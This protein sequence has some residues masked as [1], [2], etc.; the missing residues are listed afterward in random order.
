MSVR[1]IAVGLSI[2]L[3]VVSCNNSKTRCKS[4]E[5]ASDSIPILSEQHIKD[6][7]YKDPQ[8]ALRLIDSAELCR[9]LPSF[10][11]D[12]LR[13]MI[14]S[15]LRMPRVSARYGERAYASD[16]VRNSDERMLWLCDLQMNNYA[17]MNDRRRSS[18]YALK[19]LQLSRRINN[20]NSEAGFLFG[21]GMN[22]RND[23]LSRRADSCFSAAV[24]LLETSDNVR[25]M[26]SLSFFYGNMMGY[27]S[28]EDRYGEMISLG[29]KREALIKRMSTMQ[30]PPEGYIDQQ[31]AYLYSKMAVAYL[32]LG[33]RVKAEQCFKEFT[34]TKYGSATPGDSEAIPYLICSGRYAQAD[35]LCT[36]YEKLIG[37]DT[38]VRD[39]MALLDNR[40][41]LY[42]SQN[43]WHR[44]YQFSVR[45]KA[46]QEALS[47]EDAKHADLE[48]AT[49]YM[50]NEKDAMIKAKNQSLMLR[51]WLL[52]WCAV[53]I[54]ILSVLL[55]VIIR[56]NINTR[57]KNR[58]LKQKIDESIDNKAL[59]LKYRN[60]L[61]ASGQKDSKTVAADSDA[62]VGGDYETEF[63]HIDA[64]I[65]EERLF[66]NA[67]LTREDVL[68]RTT[69]P[70]YLFAGIVRQYTGT[71][72]AGYINTLRLEYALREMQEHP[73]YS[74]SG[75][76]ASCGIP[77]R[78]TFHQL[79]RAAYG[80]TPAEYRSMLST[81][82]KKQ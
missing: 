1:K 64:I 58:V 80:M 41:M 73:N 59:L 45:R 55:Y 57:R 15:N 4:V 7:Y 5:S 10:K 17:N 78:Q 8:S 60:M 13:G 35:A 66:L 74:I 77:N 22:Y 79:F 21:M 30:G 9:M 19:G 48:L 54:L 56:N 69:L 27:C 38:L 40:I 51:N 68:S 2:V 25:T 37:T 52:V 20:I 71:N 46:I 29:L 81:P 32:K 50:T 43:D 75:I 34:A 72:F 49:L 6:I 28:A 65:R 3:L 12:I 14:Y 33:D 62:A 16:S 31:F 18:E 82:D 61:A 23:K 70:K 39:Y 47:A 63:K 42:E 26:A 44:A 11:A 36:K 24:A 67:D 53:V 76:A